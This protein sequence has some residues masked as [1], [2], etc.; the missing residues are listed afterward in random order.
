MGWRAYT[1]LIPLC[2]FTTISANLH[3]AHAESLSDLLPPLLK[4]HNLVSASEAD[5]TAAKE[6]IRETQGGWFPTAELTT[7][8]GKERQNKPA[9]SINTDLITR[10]AD[11][12]VNQL[13]WDFGATNSRIHQ[14]R[15]RA[16]VSDFTLDSTKQDLILRAITA[17]LNVD[18]TARVLT[19]A[20]VSE[21]NI[22]KQTELENSLVREGAGL[23]SDVLQAKATL[24]GAQ[25]RRVRANGALSIARNA[26]RAVYHKDVND[27]TTLQKPNLPI[28]LVPATLEEA[29]DIALRKNPK[30][31]SADVGA[32]IATEDINATKASAFYPKFDFIA[33]TT[34]KDNVSGTV[35]HQEEGIAKVQMTYPFNFGLTAI[36][37]LRATQSDASSAHKRVGETR[38]LIEQLV[39]DAWTNMNTAKE[40]HKHLTNQA[41]ISAEFLGLARQ[42]RQAGTR[43]LLDVLNA[44]T[45]LINANSDAVSVEADVAIAIFSLLHSMGRLSLDTVQ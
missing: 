23:S 27:I 4:S 35:G 13:I 20:R 28:N 12:S 1:I 30:L 8:Y 36:N 22:K 42:E 31:R 14:A 25:A 45:S 16:K 5:L 32:D 43:S 11:L 33:G 39:R 34:Y 17:Y 15:L 2:S 44:E 29:V 6:R 41:N 37:T 24:S 9:G 19:F 7:Y 18:R 40:T 10:Q 38:D 21:E 3:V 26:F